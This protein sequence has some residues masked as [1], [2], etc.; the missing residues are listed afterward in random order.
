MFAVANYV[1]PVLSGVPGRMVL[2]LV[3]ALQ[4]ATIKLQSYITELES[5]MDQLKKK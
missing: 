2:L 1:T 3:Q 5:R 4:H